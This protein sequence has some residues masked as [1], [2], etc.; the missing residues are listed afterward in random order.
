MVYLRFIYIM[1][2]KRKNL[3]KKTILVTGGCG[4]IGAAITI[5]LVNEGYDVIVFDNNSRGKLSR[6]KNII[7]KIDFIKGDVRDYKSVFKIKKK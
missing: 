6:L 4:F 7:N 1:V 2:K 5:H 3:K